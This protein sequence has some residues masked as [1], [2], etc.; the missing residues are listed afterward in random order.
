MTIPARH[1]WCCTPIIPVL[2]DQEG[3][4]YMRPCLK[5][6]GK[7]KKNRRERRKEKIRKERRNYFLVKA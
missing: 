2:E 6:K 7:K 5:K 4:S 1:V 3:F